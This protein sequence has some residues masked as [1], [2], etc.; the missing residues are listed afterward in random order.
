MLCR[1]CAA[2]HA[3][4]VQNCLACPPRAVAAGLVLLAMLALS[5]LI[6]V[7]EDRRPKCGFCDHLQCFASP[8]DLELWKGCDKFRCA[9]DGAC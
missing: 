7:F 5:C 9:G 2:G 8:F 1:T 3:V 6:V 4:A